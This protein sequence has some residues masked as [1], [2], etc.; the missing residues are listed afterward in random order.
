M[1]RTEAGLETWGLETWGF[2]T[3]QQRKTAEGHCSGQQHRAAGLAQRVVQEHPQGGR[4][5]LLEWVH[6]ALGWGLG[7]GA[8]ASAL[9]IARGRGGKQQALLNQR[10][11][12]QGP[13]QT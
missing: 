13:A 3:W 1:E 7:H 2:H 6:G 4:C 12:Q 8:A 9:Q 5:P 11:V 10:D